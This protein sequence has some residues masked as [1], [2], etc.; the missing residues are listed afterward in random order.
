MTDELRS[1]QPDHRVSEADD[2][3]DA[4]PVLALVSFVLAVL[5]FA[6]FGLMNGTTYV[7][8]LLSAEPQHTR[9]LTGL[10]LGAAL[11]L[12]PVALGRRAAQLHADASWATVLAR[13]AV[14]L[15]LGSFVLRLVVAIVQATQDGPGGF[16]RL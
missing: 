16:S 9:L 15:G 1:D 2:R 4:P 8:P 14:V 12:L 5:S 3:L 7:F 6:G 13:A 11:A 10:L